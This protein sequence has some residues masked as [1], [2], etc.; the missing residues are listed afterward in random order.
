MRR[1]LIG[2]YD[3]TQVDAALRARDERLTELERQAREL[4]DRVAEAERLAGTAEGTDAPTIGA[5]S[6]RLEEMQENARRRA[7]RI[8]V[9]AQEAVQIT[10]RVGELSKLREEMGA[11][12][13]ELAGLAGIRVG[14]EKRRA[15]GTEPARTAADG[16]YS[17]AV[18]VEVGPLR[19]FAQLTSFEDAAASIDAAS[20]VHVTNF[21]D[22]RATFSINFAQPVDLVREL[23]QRTPFPFSVREA[24]L[25]GMVL[26]VEGSP[27]K[28]RAA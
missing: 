19:D 28:D 13:T 25:E 24:H 8:R 9:S 17:G 1:A 16:V 23:E 11:V 10:E 20:G 3:R 7:G 6:R 26:D 15:V 14:G 12:V 4:A 22:G 2:G 21:A 18:E 27:H 5:L